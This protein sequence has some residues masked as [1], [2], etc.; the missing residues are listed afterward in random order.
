MRMPWINRET[1]VVNRFNIIINTIAN[2]WRTIRFDSIHKIWL[3]HLIRHLRNKMQL[4]RQLHV[5]V[6]LKTTEKYRETQ[7]TIKSLRSVSSLLFKVRLLYFSYSGANFFMLFRVCFFS[8]DK[9]NWKH[10]DNFSLISL[11]RSVTTRLASAQENSREKE[12]ILW[13][14]KLKNKSNESWSSGSWSYIWWIKN[15]GENIFTAIEIGIKKS[16]IWWYVK[17]WK[18]SIIAIVKK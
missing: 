9:C 1:E 4:T 10:S 18:I 17:N 7:K 11:L 2:S 12:I 8:V 6:Q 16:C 14:E 3:S 15:F 5:L 13:R